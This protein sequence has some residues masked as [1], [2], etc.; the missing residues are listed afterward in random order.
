MDVDK[1]VLLEFVKSGVV[2]M[3]LFADGKAKFQFEGI[4]GVFV[5]RDRVDVVIAG[6]EFSL[7]GLIHVD[8][9]FALAEE[10][11]IEALGGLNAGEIVGVTIADDVFLGKKI[12]IIAGDGDGVFVLEIAEGADGVDDIALGLGERFDGRVVFAEST[13]ERLD[14]VDGNGGNG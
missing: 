10:A 14:E 7:P 9:A 13:E 6:A 8:G 1:P 2:E 11:L 3:N 12:E 4:E 5:I